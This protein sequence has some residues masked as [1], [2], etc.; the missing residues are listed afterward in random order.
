MIYKNKYMQRFLLRC[1]YKI[2]QGQKYQQ[3]SNNPMAYSKFFNRSKC[4]TFP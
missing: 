3:N 2:K 4:G 1:M